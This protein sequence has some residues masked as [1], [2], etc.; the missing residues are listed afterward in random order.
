MNKIKNSKFTRAKILKLSV[1]LLVLALII[2]GAFLFASCKKQDDLA[3]LSQNKTE[4]D[5]ALD[6]N[7][8]DYSFNAKQ[9]VSYYNCTGAI[10]KNVKFHLYPQFF[11]EGFE[12]KVV[13]NTQYNQA[14][15][16]GKSYASFNIDSLMVNGQAQTVQYS[17]ECDGIL[18]VDLFSSLLPEER[19]EIAIN[20]N[21]SLGNC[22]HRFGYGEN[23]INVCNFYPVVCVYENGAFDEHGYHPN[24]DPFYSDVSNYSV[25]V[26]TD[27]QY[28]VVASGQRSDEKISNNK[29]TTTFK[30]L[31]VRDF[32]LVLSSKFNVISQKQDDINV[33]YYYFDDENAAQSL[34]AGVDAIK[35]FSSKFGQYPYAN[36]CIVKADFIYGGMEYPN[37]IMISSDIK[38]LD[39][40]LNVIVHETA[41]QWWY[42][43]V[44]NN[45]YVYPWLD[46]A[47]T[48]YST[49]LFYDYNSGY[50]LTHKDMIN[51]NHDNYLLFT[52]VYEDVLGSL[53]TSMRAVDEYP[54]EPEYTYCT[55]V[56]GVLMFD[57]VYNL[58][59]EKAFISSLGQYYNN[60]KYKN[61]TPDDLISAF[62]KASGKDLTGVFDSWVKGKVVIR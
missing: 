47:L 44:G 6:F 19:V 16:H 29:K 20:Y 41:H 17:G 57:S 33:E 26:T 58:I 27:P 54:T 60:C 35:T 15:P 53:D 32:G 46:E 23:T 55:Y 24:G 51:I 4:Y 5:I 1:I 12:Q 48:E 38:N 9:K 62:N 22:L 14:Y 18:S 28:T 49:L 11:E 37:M 10:L 21:F 31:M 8:A 40:Y 59:G 25:T 42:G 61:A 50:N 43:L 52:T 36:F 7:A 2:S 45:E 3:K 13:P 30:A 56:K 34:K 39:D